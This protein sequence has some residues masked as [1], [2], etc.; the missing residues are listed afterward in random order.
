MEAYKG[1][2]IIEHGNPTKPWGGGGLLDRGGGGGGGTG[3]RIDYQRKEASEGGNAGVRVWRPSPE[4]W[5]LRSVKQCKQA[6]KTPCGSTRRTRNTQQIG[7]GQVA[8]N[9][10]LVPPYEVQGETERGAPESKKKAKNAN[11]KLTFCK[12][13]ANSRSAGGSKAKLSVGEEYPESSIDK[14]HRGTQRKKTNGRS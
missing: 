12:K 4:I 14:I 2:K 6:I 13:G 9:L 8:K 11:K 7:R 5:K 10:C 1:G 3:G